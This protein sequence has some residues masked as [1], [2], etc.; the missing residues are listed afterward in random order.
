MSQFEQWE[1]I[2]FNQQL[3]KSTSKTFQMFKQAYSEEA[4]VL[5]A[6]F[7]WHKRFAHGRENL[8]DDEHTGQLRMFRTELKIQEAAT[9]VCANRSQMVDEVAAAANI[10]HGTWH[11]FLSDDLNISRFTKHGVLCILMLDQCDDRM[12]TCGDLIDSAGKNGT[13]L[14]RIITGDKT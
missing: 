1:N 7:K 8:K 6:M 10:S 9:L 5:N 4:L 12:S 11:R 2:K 3:H 14:N 13:F